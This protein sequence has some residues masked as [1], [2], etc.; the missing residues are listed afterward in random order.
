ME[1]KENEQEISEKR[2]RNEDSKDQSKEDPSYKEYIKGKIKEK[3]SKFRDELL[4]IEHKAVDFLNG[5]YLIVQKNHSIREYLKSVKN[6]YMNYFFNYFGYRYES[7]I[8]N[9]NF[10]HF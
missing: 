8:D 2:S 1:H 6:Y 4:S 7:I 3:A 9:P 10:F 5:V